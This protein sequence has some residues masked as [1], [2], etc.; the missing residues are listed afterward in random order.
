MNRNKGFFLDLLAYLRGEEPTAARP[1]PVKD[2]ELPRWPGAQPPAPASGVAA[3]RARLQAKL[4]L[5][6][7]EGA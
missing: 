2:R 1:R 4:E 5:A 6:Q 7:K 3:E